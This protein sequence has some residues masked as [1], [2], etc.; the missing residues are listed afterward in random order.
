MMGAT[1]RMACDLSALA[2]QGLRAEVHRCLAS[3]MRYCNA[4]LR[5]PRTKPRMKK[6]VAWSRLPDDRIRLQAYAG[7][8]QCRHLAPL[9]RAQP[10]HGSLKIIGGFV[11]AVAKADCQNRS[12]RAKSVKAGCYLLIGY[13][14][15]AS[16]TKVQAS[17]PHIA[18]SCLVDFIHYALHSTSRNQ[19]AELLQRILI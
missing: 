16:S 18:L 3:R 6:S 5:K 11:N 12:E 14:L 8:E 1:L 9:C 15:Y 13:T 7:R 10:A 17:A 19:Y 4:F 2:K